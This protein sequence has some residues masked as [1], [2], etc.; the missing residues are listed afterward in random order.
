MT[1]EKKKNI[2]ISYTEF[3]VDSTEH[4]GKWE[5]V[6]WEGKGI[7]R[8][9]FFIVFIELIKVQLT[10]LTNSPTEKIIYL[11]MCSNGDTP[12]VSSK[13]AL[14]LSEVSLAFLAELKTIKYPSTHPSLRVLEC[15]ENFL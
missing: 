14:S 13:N 15:L 5:C 10:I 7:E 4:W 3:R 1:Q 2:K 9:N 6:G 12:N 11:I 8:K